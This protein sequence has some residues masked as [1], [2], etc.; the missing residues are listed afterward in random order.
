MTPF[1]NFLKC[2]KLLSEASLKHLRKSLTRLSVPMLLN[3][4]LLA[5]HHRH[6]VLRSPPSML[7]PSMEGQDPLNKSFFQ[8]G[9]EGY[10]AGFYT[11]PVAT[12]N[13]AKCAQRAKNVQVRFKPLPVI[14]FSQGID[15]H[16]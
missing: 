3:P 7:A 16:V 1:L 10:L 9:F 2:S 13:W 4:Q 12:P 5:S 15:I 11:Y 6:L 8:Y 14:L